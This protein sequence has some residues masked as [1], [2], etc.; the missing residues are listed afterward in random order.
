M[1]QLLQ[2]SAENK[3]KGCGQKIVYV[4]KLWF[5]CEEDG[6]IFLDFQELEKTYC[7]CALKKF[8]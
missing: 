1:E 2:K 6:R 7:M 5:M 8:F 4:A 3:T